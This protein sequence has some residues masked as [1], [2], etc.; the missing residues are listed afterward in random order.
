MGGVTKFKQPDFDAL[1]AFKYCRFVAEPYR[2]VEIA[3]D[4]YSNFTYGA[5]RLYWYFC[6][7]VTVVC[8]A[9]LKVRTHC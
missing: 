6:R 4:D 8:I 2:I 5:I 3:N 7:V 9:Y 1:G